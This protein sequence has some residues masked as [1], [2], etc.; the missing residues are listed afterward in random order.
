MKAAFGKHGCPCL[1]QQREVRGWAPG[2]SPCT[3]QVLSSALN[4]GTGKWSWTDA[5]PTQAL[6]KLKEDYTPNASPTS[7]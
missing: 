4:P 2:Q 1:L 6:F 3:L 7:E 5:V